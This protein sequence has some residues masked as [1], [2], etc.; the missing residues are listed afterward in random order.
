MRYLFFRF[1][2]KILDSAMGIIVFHKYN[3]KS[4]E[5]IDITEVYYYESRK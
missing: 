1:C 2:Q 3:E 4:C 5:I